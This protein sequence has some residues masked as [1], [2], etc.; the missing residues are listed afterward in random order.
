MCSEIKVLGKIEA[1][2]PCDCCG[3]KVLKVAVVIDLEGLQVHYGRECAGKLL[4]GSK[5]AANGRKAERAA[6]AA[7]FE[8]SRDR[9]NRLRRVAS[10][11]MEAN[12]FYASSRRPLAG[13]YFASNGARVVRVDGSDS[14]DVAFFAA[15]GFVA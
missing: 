10:D 7:A 4:Y 2:R 5:S 13:S 11:K 9:D 8:A 14:R 6:D 12:R 15:E 1:E 3:N